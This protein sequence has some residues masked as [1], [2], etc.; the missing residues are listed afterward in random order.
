M[1]RFKLDGITYNVSLEKYKDMN[2][3]VSKLESK[4]RL[5]SNSIE[6]LLKK[7]GVDADKFSKKP[8][9]KLRESKAGDTKNSGDTI[10]KG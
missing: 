8:V 9:K 4:S 2:D 3:L 6:K 5:N 10:G 1:V 7:Q